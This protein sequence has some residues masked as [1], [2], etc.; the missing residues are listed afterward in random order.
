MGFVLGLFL[1]V[2]VLGIV[3][4]PFVYIGYGLATRRLTFRG[5]RVLPPKS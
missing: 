2:F 5:R 1:W 3:I 4:G